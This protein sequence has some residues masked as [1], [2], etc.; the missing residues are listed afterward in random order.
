MAIQYHFLSSMGLH[1]D[2]VSGVTHLERRSICLSSFPVFPKECV[3]CVFV[4]GVF[5]VANSTCLRHFFLFSSIARVVWGGFLLN[6]WDPC[7][8]DVASPVRASQRLSRLWVFWY[9]VGDRRGSIFDF[10]AAMRLDGSMVW[11][12]RG[13]IS[14]CCF[15]WWIIGLVVRWLVLGL[16]YPWWILT[17]V[18]CWRSRASSFFADS[19]N[20]VKLMAGSGTTRVWAQIWIWT[21][22]GGLC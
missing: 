15:G 13:S 19:G 10:C 2:I 12:K 8:W 16:A 22:C 20:N 4:L 14:D 11:L 3:A 5:W 7:C 21:F 6:L 18:W 17:D 1:S 9:V